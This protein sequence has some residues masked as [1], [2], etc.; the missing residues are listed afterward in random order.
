MI[1]QVELEPFSV[2]VTFTDGLVAL[3]VLRYS[4]D[5]E[6]SS[7]PPIKIWFVGVVASA[8]NSCGNFVEVNGLAH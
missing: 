4:S 2:I 1:S 5:R 6:T 8:S 7:E 3:G